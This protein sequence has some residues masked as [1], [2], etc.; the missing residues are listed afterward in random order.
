MV[1]SLIHDRKTDTAG[2]LGGGMALLRDIYR[3]NNPP[4]PCPT[5]PHNIFSPKTI[6]FG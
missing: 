1:F 3:I 5:T 6:D 4:H 2:G